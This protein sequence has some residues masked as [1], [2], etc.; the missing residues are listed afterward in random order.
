[1]HHRGSELL[2]PNSNVMLKLQII[3]N[4]GSD[5]EVRNQDGRSYVSFRVAHTDRRQQADGSVKETTQWVSCSIN[6]D[7]GKLLPYLKKGAK[8]YI[9][10]DGDV[11]L[12][13]SSKEHCLKA[14][15]NCYVRDIELVTTNL[16]AV[17]RELYDENGAVHAVTKCYGV[18]DM[19]KGALY[20]RRGLLYQ[21]DKG[22]VIP[23]PAVQEEPTPETF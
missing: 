8:V 15:L 12:Y 3:G 13:N 2:T 6:G 5:A 9:S 21:V 4:L 1:M 11:R 16:D 22:W 20:D 19:K 23:R 7:G 17:P 18:A 14:G 10:G